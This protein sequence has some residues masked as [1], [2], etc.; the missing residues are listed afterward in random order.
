MR[1]LT[2]R[3]GKNTQPSRRGQALLLVMMMSIFTMGIWAVSFRSTRDAID[4]ESFHTESS[5]YEQRIV[6]GLAWA[7]HL[8][9]QEEPS[10]S[11][12]SFLYAGNDAKGQFYTTVVIRR[13]GT[14]SYEVTAR[15]AKTSEVRRLHRNPKHF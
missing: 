3:H 6:K 7:G 14:E 2:Q 9:E 11:T 13:R 1:I 10:V 5:R 8:L 12:Y 4:T 15:P